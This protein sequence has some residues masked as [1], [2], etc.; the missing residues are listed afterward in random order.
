MKK[1]VALK[2]A[3][4]TKLPKRSAARDLNAEL[5]ASIADVKAG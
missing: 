4:V 1:S 3:K 5:L 2:V